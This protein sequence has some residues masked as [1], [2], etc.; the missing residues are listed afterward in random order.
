MV[1]MVG[2]L[3]IDDRRSRRLQDG[4]QEGSRRAQSFH[5]AR[6]ADNRS[7]QHGGAK[8]DKPVNSLWTSCVHA[9]EH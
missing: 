8:L 5:A 3:K 2:I 9:G 1:R 7:T 6:A 4:W